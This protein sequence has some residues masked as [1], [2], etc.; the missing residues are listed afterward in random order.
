MMRMRTRMVISMRRSRGD[1]LFVICSMTCVIGES[2]DYLIV[3]LLCGTSLLYY[4]VTLICVQL[5]ACILS[6]CFVA[7]VSPLNL[8]G[9]GT[10]AYD[11]V[12]MYAIRSIG[13]GSCSK[14]GDLIWKLIVSYVVH[15]RGYLNLPHALLFPMYA[16]ARRLVHQV[17]RVIKSYLGWGWNV[18]GN[19]MC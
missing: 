8:H 4:F 9:L 7:L 15:V 3:V 12:C 16:C 18:V 19:Q 13:T 5:F 1:L 17:L 14:Y 10:R 6:Y 11:T 2:W